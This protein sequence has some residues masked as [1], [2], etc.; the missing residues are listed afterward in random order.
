[1]KKVWI[2]R[3]LKNPL[4]Q[5]APR[6]RRRS[7]GVPTL[8]TVALLVIAL[9]VGAL[10]GFAL[11][12]RS[13]PNKKALTASQAR[14]GEL[15]Q[16]G[17]TREALERMNADFIRENISPGGS[18]DLLALSWFLYLITNENGGTTRERNP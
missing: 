11:A 14:A 8:L 4:P 3:R 7:A 16:T 5:S 9:G 17:F 2:R 10:A 6:R 12:R 13:D 18:A 15:A 1:M